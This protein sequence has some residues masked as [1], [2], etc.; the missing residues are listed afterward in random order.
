ML[1]PTKNLTKRSLTIAGHRT[2]ISL[3]TEFWT[4]LGEA[5][6]TQNKSLAALVGEIDQL[7]QGRNLS[8][9]IRVWL[10]S[11]AQSNIPAP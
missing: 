2:S 7:R 8:S 5:A 6:K 11:R 10:F 3:E 4:A 9:A 1:D